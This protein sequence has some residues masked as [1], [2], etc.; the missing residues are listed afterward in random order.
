MEKK[1]PCLYG[2]I[3][4][5]DVLDEIVRFKPKMIISTIHLF[6]DNIHLTKFFKNRNKKL[7]VYATGKNVDE[8]LDLYDAGANYVIVPHL[9]GGERVADLLKHTL[10]SKQQLKTVKKKHIKHLLSIH[11]P[12]KV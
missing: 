3:S 8:A 4:D 12:K 10:K 2:D 7:Q 1:V 6:E 9:L 11:L 5:H